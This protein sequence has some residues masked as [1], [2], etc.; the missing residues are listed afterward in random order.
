MSSSAL[1]VRNQKAPETA[2]SLLSA[3]ERL[4]RSCRAP[5]PKATAEYLLAGVLGVERTE[6]VLLGN[7]P[8]AAGRKYRRLAAAVGRRRLPLAYALG[9]QDF[10]GLDLRLRPG[11]VLIPRPETESLVELA[12]RE[13]KLSW[14]AGAKLTIADI[15][16][17][18][19]NIALALRR[20]LGDAYSL[21]IW[22]TDCSSAALSVAR[23]NGRRLNDLGSIRWVKGPLFERLPSKIRFHAIVSNP[24]YIAEGDWAR[25]SPEIKRW[26]PKSALA[27]GPDGLAVIRPLIHEAPRR[28]CPGGLL[29]FEFGRGQARTIE[30]LLKQN[31]FHSLKLMKDYQG[32]FRVV[33]ARAS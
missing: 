21:E 29:A 15:G 25:L 1:R 27:A 30:S 8:A 2:S 17:G 26:E 11:A 19:G 24:P 4:L 3:A 7:V 13:I 5:E 6:L 9:S 31:G 14:S 12:V 23:K 33:L 18:S 22:A 16:T 32:F 28:L 20:F 10:M